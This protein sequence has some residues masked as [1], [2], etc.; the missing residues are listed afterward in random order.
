MSTSSTDQGTTPRE[1][2]EGS[3]PQNDKTCPVCKGLGYVRADVP[4]NHPDFGKLVPC[5]CRLEEITE[6]RITALRTLSE[7]EVLGRMTF[8]AFEPEGHGL[9]PDKA[10]NLRWAYDTSKAFAEHPDLAREGLL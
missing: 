8:D 2:T 9:P 7:L 3:Q 6:Q 10:S 4:V 1:T 5:A